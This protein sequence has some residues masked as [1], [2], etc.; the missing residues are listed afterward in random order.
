[1]IKISIDKNINQIRKE[2]WKLHD[3]CRRIWN[4]TPRLISLPLLVT[5]YNLVAIWIV[6]IKMQKFGNLK[7]R[8]RKSG[9]QGSENLDIW[10]ARCRVVPPLLVT[11]NDVPTTGPLL[12]FWAALSTNHY[13][14]YIAISKIFLQTIDLND[15]SAEI[16]YH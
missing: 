3:I 5:C 9:N 10:K 11:R 14:F 12:L 13:L 8:W 7:S 15:C 6:E 16:Y 1:M 2:K 4:S